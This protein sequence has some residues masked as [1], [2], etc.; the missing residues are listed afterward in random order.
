[1]L[2]NYRNLCA[3]TTNPSQLVLPETLTLL[4]LYIL[5]ALKMPALKM[6]STT[7]L[8]QKVAQVQSILSMSME[9][10]SYQLY[11]RVYKITDLGH[12]DMYGHVD[13]STQLIVKPNLLPCRGSKLSH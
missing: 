5:V 9:Q 3:N 8:D 4:P 1:M 10:L 6:L 13:D 11:P 7:F 2:T 12:S